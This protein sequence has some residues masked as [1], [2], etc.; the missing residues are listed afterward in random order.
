MS[1]SASNWAGARLVGLVYGILTGLVA[2]IVLVRI[3]VDLV[4][5]LLPLLL[6]VGFMEYTHLQHTDKPFV[7]R[8]WVWSRPQVTKS[9]N[10]NFR[11]E[12]DWCKKS[13]LKSEQIKMQT[14]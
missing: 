8:C 4:L 10:A 13:K 2:A 1:T 12:L 3:T 11:P 14:N 7:L 9:N 6:V 5:L